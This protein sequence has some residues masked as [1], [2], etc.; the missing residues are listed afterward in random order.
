MKGFL[1]RLFLTLLF[2]FSVVYL[3]P[4]FELKLFDRWIV[5]EGIPNIF[6]GANLEFAQYNLT[7]TYEYVVISTLSNLSDTDRFEK[8]LRDAEVIRQRLKNSFGDAFEVRT[9]FYDGLVRHKVYVNKKVYDTN[10]LTTVENEFAVIKKTTQSLALDNQDQVSSTED[11]SGGQDVE[12]QVG[13]GSQEKLGFVRDDFGFAEVN[14]IKGFSNEIYY[15][16]KLPFSYLIS[17]QKISQAKDVVGQNLSM[18]IGGNDVSVYVDYNQNYVPVGLVISGLKSLDEA[19]LIKSLLNSGRLNLVYKL[20]STTLLDRRNGM[21]RQYLILAY[22]FVFINTI[23]FIL[24]RMRVMSMATGMFVVNL[25]LLLGLVVSKVLGIAVSLYSFLIL[26]FCI[27]LCLNHLYMSVS[28]FSFLILFWLL[29]LI[30]N[31]DGYD[32]S[33]VNMLVLTLQSVAF[34]TFLSATQYYKYVVSWYQNKF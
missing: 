13:A 3:V 16:V 6:G 29:K 10:L 9:D 31:L 26:G 12:L 21:Y 2:L 17:S 23:V 14:K 33:F 15:L 19:V 1:S 24:S 4:P 7:P 25:L 18:Q 22:F 34:F 32:I 28:L 30:L 27:L 8:G 5:Y 20:E 11:V